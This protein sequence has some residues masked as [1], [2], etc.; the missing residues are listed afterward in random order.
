M[1]KETNVSIV[2]KTQT[3]IKKP[4]KQPGVIYDISLENT[5]KIERKNN[6]FLRTLEDKKRGWLWIAK[7]IKMIGGTRVEIED[8]KFFF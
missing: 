3:T 5:L 6:A 4:Q 8:K 7:T 1:R 2:E